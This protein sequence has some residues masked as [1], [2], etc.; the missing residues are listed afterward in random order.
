MLH[1]TQAESQPLP[2]IV[3][4]RTDAE[5][6]DG[7]AAIMSGMS[8]SSGAELL[9]QELLRARIVE[10][11]EIPASTVTMHAVVEFRDEGS[12]AVRVVRLVYPG[13]QREAS[14]DAVS[15]LAPVGA[16]LIGLSEG[17]SI[18]YMGADRRPRRITVLKVLSQPGGSEIPAVGRH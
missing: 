2:D 18:S 5:K 6:L 8:S 13:E 10:A 1:Q 4:T 9:L 11:G 14:V 3:V 7:L 15:V 12:G 17:Q 16:A